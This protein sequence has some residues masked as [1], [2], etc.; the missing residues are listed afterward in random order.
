MDV[1]QNP[2]QV[3]IWYEDSSISAHIIVYAARYIYRKKM[4]FIDHS[5]IDYYSR[6]NGFGT[7][8]GL[9]GA[10]ICA[11]ITSEFGFLVGTA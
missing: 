8:A 5:V 2:I 6:Q 11:I 9:T 7:A 1:S 10:S 3:R 4:M